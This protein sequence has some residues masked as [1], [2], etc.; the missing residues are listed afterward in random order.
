MEK[1]I[2]RKIR[3]AVVGCGRISKNHFGSIEQHQEKIELVSICDARPN[4]LS[5]HEKKYKVKGYLDLDDMLKN[6]DLD[7][8]TLCTP[9]GV[10]AEQTELC[11]KHKINVVTEKPMATRWEDGKR[12]V[13]ACDKAGVKLLVVKQNRR[14]PTLQLLKRA[15][16]EK[17]FGKIHMVHLNIFWTRSQEYYDQATWRGTCA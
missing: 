10:H 12:M 5:E 3:I 2:H 6:E 17:R 14:N 16:T 11:A 9:S 4:I 15:I 13:K 8:V 7:L 1:I